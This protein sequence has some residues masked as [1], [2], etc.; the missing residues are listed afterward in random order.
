M[1]FLLVL[2]FHIPY[3]FFPTKESFLIIFDEAKNKSM[4]KAIQKKLQARSGDK[5]KQPE[6]DANTSNTI[7]ESEAETAAEAGA[8]GK[9]NEAE[10][11]YLKMAPWKYYTLTLS[12][13]IGCILASIFIDDIAAVF[14]FVGAFGLSLTSFTLPG[15]MY[16]LML[17]NPNANHD[18]ETV[19]QRRWNKAGAILV[20]SLSI[21]NMCLV[22]YK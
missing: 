7:D 18:I 5:S 13:Y 17:R 9:N 15:V 12:L 16:L 19:R 1:A 20:I 22:L 3:I 8:E 10:L 4:A 11:A 14:E 21:F 6:S 2:A